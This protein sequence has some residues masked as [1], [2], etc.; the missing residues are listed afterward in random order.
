[1]AKPSIAE[2]EARLNE[3]DEK[4]DN[5]QEQIQLQQEQIQSLV[6]GIENLLEIARRNQERIDQV[7]EHINAAKESAVQTIDEKLDT[8]LG[9]LEQPRG[10][11]S[12]P[13]RAATGGRLTPFQEASRDVPRI[14]EAF[15]RGTCAGHNYVHL[16]KHGQCVECINEATK[17]LYEQRRA[18]TA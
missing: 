8:I 6:T 2:L 14:G 5:Q 11:T 18:V 9:R 4:I 10:G 1:M 15:G 7:F 3:Q 17:A 12:I 13:N 16:N